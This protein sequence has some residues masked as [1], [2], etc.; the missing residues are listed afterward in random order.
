M[1]LDIFSYYG[2]FSLLALACTCLAVRSRFL[3]WWV[4]VCLVTGGMLLGAYIIADHFTGQGI[5]EAALYHIPHVFTLP[6]LQQFWH[7]AGAALL[8]LLVLLVA[9]WKLGSLLVNAKRV[10]FLSHQSSFLINIVAVLSAM[11]S[12][13]FHPGATA[14]VNAV[15]EMHSLRG[16]DL[17]ADYIHNNINTVKAERPKSFVYIYLESMDRVFLNE[18]RF[19]GLMPHLKD[20]QTKALD[21]R[22]LYQAP[23]TGWTMAGIVSSQCG[24]PL[25][26][27]ATA[28]KTLGEG[29]KIEC[30]G[31]FL[32]P[33]G[34]HLNFMG[35][36][37]VTFAG[38]GEFFLSRGFAEIYGAED[39]EVMAGKSLPRSLWGVYDDDLFTLVFRRFEELA[40]QHERFGLIALTLDT[41]PPEGHKTPACAANVY[42]NG[43]SQTLNAVHCTDKLLHEFIQRFNASP[44]SQDVV[45]LISSDHLMMANDAG[46]E[47]D[48]GQRENLFLALNTGEPPRI[49]QRSGTMMD[50]AP[51]WLELIGFSSDT[52]HLG[53]NLLSQTPTLVEHWGKEEFYRLLKVWRSNLWDFWQ[54]N[55]AEDVAQADI[56]KH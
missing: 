22:G 31:D 53:S 16:P 18:K 49:I 4:I 51:T 39:L 45:L 20:Y 6:V 11:A 40:Q 42:G 7:I 37:D 47:A 8:A 13:V 36:A 25:A 33:L 1:L 32:S 50:V 21:F 30:L 28:N 29:K 34:Y 54:S 35:G 14:L 46:L 3:M 26:R 9:L 17:V 52:I 56:Q 55:P 24:L 38:K 41:H 5:N 27:S 23:M 15:Q 12:L 10:G 2:F 43:S 48:N 19:P 44:Y